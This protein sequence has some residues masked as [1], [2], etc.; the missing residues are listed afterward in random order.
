MKKL[1]ICILLL[2]V[3]SLS[4]CAQKR[5]KIEKQLLDLGISENYQICSISGIR[6]NTQ[7]VSFCE[8]IKE[9]IYK[10]KKEINSETIDYPSYT[11]RDNLIFFF[12]RYYDDNYICGYINFYSL[13]IIYEYFEGKDI[14]PSYK[15]INENFVIITI[16]SNEYIV[17]D[18][19]KNTFKKVDD[20]E[21]NKY[22]CEEIKHNYND[23]YI[24]N[25]KEYIIKNEENG[26]EIYYNEK[27]KVFINNDYIN[28][29][30]AIYQEIMNIVDGTSRTIEW[31]FKI[32][33]N[34]LYIIINSELT[35][36]GR[37]NLIPIVF[38]Y[39]IENEEF[40]FVGSTSYYKILEI[41]KN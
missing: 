23:K 41:R 19:K 39:N 28:E 4:S 20:N 5:D 38:R 17:I 7:N 29:K 27:R 36:F 34:E 2:C 6:S 3:I 16:C 32:N 31:N 12:V 22:F 35:M 18:Y 40:Y 30:S 13:E 25:S 33:N 9:Q 26:I 15:H 21:I 10:D 8:L 24:E 11:Y 37:G 1:L 14:N